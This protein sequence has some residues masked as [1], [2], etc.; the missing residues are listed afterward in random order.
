M[1]GQNFAQSRSVGFGV[2]EMLRLLILR[3]RLR[4]VEGGTDDD[5]EEEDDEEVAAVTWARIWR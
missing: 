1:C 5:G 2:A 3:T 4:S